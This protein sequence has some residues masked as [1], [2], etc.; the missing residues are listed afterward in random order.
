[1]KR[2]YSISNKDFFGGVYGKLPENKQIDEAISEVMGR[3]DG[4]ELV[5][6]CDKGAARDYH[7]IY[8]IEPDGVVFYFRNIL[9]VRVIEIGGDDRSLDRAHGIFKK[10]FKKQPFGL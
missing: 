10:A 2:E 4:S 1:M 9:R 8:S 7:A 3:V 5:L 6:D